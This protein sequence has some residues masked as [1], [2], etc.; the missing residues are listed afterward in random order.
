MARWTSTE[1]IAAAIASDRGAVE[2][3]IESIWPGC[4]RLSAMPATL[5]AASLARA[6]QMTSP[7]TFLGGSVAE[8]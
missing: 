3:L 1:I 2:R 4:Y 5:S 7:L 6:E 8:R